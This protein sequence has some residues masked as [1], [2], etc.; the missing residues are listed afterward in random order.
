MITIRPAR[1]EDIAAITDIYNEATLTT[2]ASFDTE[3]KTVAE[4]EVWFDAH[5]DKHPILVAEIAGEVVAWASLSKWSDRCAYTDTVENSLY[6]KEEFRCRG[7]GRQLLAA[8]LDAG[9]QAGVHTII[10]RI[11]S[12]NATSLHLHAELGFVDIGTMRE[13][14][15]KFGRMLDVVLMQYIYKDK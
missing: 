7:I 9:A 10:A 11:T 2:T 15:Q 12:D 14:G 1:R 4:Q 5:G 6:V 3:P 8:L 13:V